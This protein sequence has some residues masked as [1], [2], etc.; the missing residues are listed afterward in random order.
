MSLTEVAS[1]AYRVTQTT[2]P[3][4]MSYTHGKNKSQF[5]LRVL[6]NDEAIK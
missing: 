1:Y 2:E 4:L 3:H 6:K 5:F